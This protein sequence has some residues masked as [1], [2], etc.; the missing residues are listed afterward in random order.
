MLEAIIQNEA[1][2][3]RQR[4]RLNNAGLPD[5]ER[6]RSALA[7]Y[8]DEN[9]YIGNAASIYYSSSWVEKKHINCS[10]RKSLLDPV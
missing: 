4:Q 5:A 6:I 3:I 9:Y 2:A 1:E 8:V 7:N 10:V